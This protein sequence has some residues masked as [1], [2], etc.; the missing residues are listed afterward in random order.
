[1]EKKM[2]FDFRDDIK[3]FSSGMV[4]ESMVKESKV[5]YECKEK[6]YFAFIDALGFKEAFDEY[7]LLREHKEN[8]SNV[9][10]EK[11]DYEKNSRKEIAE[12]KVKKFKDVF[13][14]YF[15]IM[16]NLP[17]V[18]GKLYYCG[19]VSDTLYFFTDD[20]RCLV[21]YIK[22]FLVFN[23]YA[24]SRDVFFRGG[25]ATGNLYKAESYQYYGDSV[26][27][28][29]LLEEKIAKFPIVILSK[30][31]VND[32][33]SYREISK[34]FEKQDIKERIYLK[35]FA[36]L[37]EDN[38][39]VTGL[40]LGWTASLRDEKFV[41]D[42][43]KNITGNIKKFEYDNSNYSKYIKLQELFEKEV[44]LYKKRRKKEKTCMG[45]RE[46]IRNLQM[47]NRR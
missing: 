23:I 36:F 34:V 38:F 43:K 33:E 25:I 6:V 19:Q 5:Q 16:E 2:P 14:K 46:R 8:Q 11:N 4:K 9:D 44:H 29:Y 10:D 37:N 28:A 18:S 13:E 24:M 26:S 15:S 32:L 35:P 20:E 39:E 17:G 41:D 31:V 21:E 45:Q 47:K 42:I 22:L 27:R 12:D 1:M 30:D 3:N 7:Q 40:N